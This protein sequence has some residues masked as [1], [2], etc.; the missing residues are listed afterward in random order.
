M[1]ERARE[2]EKERE[3]VR[4]RVHGYMDRNPFKKSSND[5]GG[6]VSNYPEQTGG[7][8]SLTSTMGAWVF[9][10]LGLKVQGLEFRVQGSGFRVQGSGFGGRGS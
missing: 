9:Q 6:N 7:A 5:L 4:G 10:G 8:L 1:R 2:R 3:R